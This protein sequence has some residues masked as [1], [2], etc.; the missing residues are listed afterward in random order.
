[1]CTD[2]IRGIS[3]V[4]S[5]VLGLGWLEFQIESLLNILSDVVV[6]QGRV[7]VELE[8]LEQD[9]N[10]FV[11]LNGVRAILVEFVDDFHDVLLLEDVFAA[12]E[13]IQLTSLD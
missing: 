13:V 9:S 4:R 10:K 1:M 7:D 2:C 12:H 6:S 5:H 11:E 3:I 8:I